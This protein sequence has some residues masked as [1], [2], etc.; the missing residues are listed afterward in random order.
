MWFVLFLSFFHGYLIGTNQ[1]TNEYLKKIWRNGPINPFSCGKILENVLR[2]GIGE[3][4]FE[5]FDRQM[6]VS[7]NFDTYSISP[8][9]E[10]FFRGEV[11]VRDEMDRMQTH[12]NKS[13][14]DEKVDLSGV[15]KKF[16]FGENRGGG[17][18][19]VMD[20]TQDEKIY[21]RGELD[22]SENRSILNNKL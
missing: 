13:V 4:F 6:S 11:K 2:V 17:E 20:F 8:S 18:D 1:T 7:L 10:G 5:H 16:G 14:Y 19:K 21:G 15:C 22:D 12:V 3:S 9:K